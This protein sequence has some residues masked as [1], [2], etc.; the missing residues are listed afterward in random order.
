MVQI[1]M[2][3]R[4]KKLKEK[5]KQWNYEKEWQRNGKGKIKVAL[6]ESIDNLPCINDCIPINCCS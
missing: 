2:N 6:L 1:C 4:K 5:K 3:K